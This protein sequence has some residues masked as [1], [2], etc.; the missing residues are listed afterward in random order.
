[1]TPIQI[2][3]NR[4]NSDI[5]DKILFLNEKES[6]RNPHEKIHNEVINESAEKAIERI[7]IH[8]PNKALHA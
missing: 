2:W 4:E 6:T 8:L 5:L 3:S 7:D 1:M